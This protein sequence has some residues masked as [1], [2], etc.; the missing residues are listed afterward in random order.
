MR[1]QANPLPLA[2]GSPASALSEPTGLRRDCSSGIKD[3][4]KRQFGGDARA[5]LSAHPEVE[6]DHS[7]VVDLI[8]DEY[9]QLVDTG[10]PP[11]PDA[12]CARYPE[13]QAELQELLQAHSFMRANVDLWANGPVRSWP[14]PGTT[15]LGFSL[16]R[17][18]GRGAFSQ[19]FLARESALGG[20]LVALKVTR[21]GTSEAFTLGRLGHP[22][23][24]PVYSVREDKDTGLTAVC[25]PYLG[26]ATLAH[27][28]EHAF[29]ESRLPR[30]AAVI[31]EAVQDSAVAAEQLGPTD[32][33]SSLL[34]RGSYVEGVLLLGA[35]LAEALAFIHERGI[36]HRDLKPSNVL[37]SP[38][39][40][41]FLLDFNLAFDQ[42]LADGLLGGTWPY[43]APEQLQAT[44]SEQQTENPSLDGR[45]DLFSLGVILYELLTGKHPFG[46]IPS[47]FEIPQLRAQ[48]LERQAKGAPNAHEL[49]PDVELPLARFLNRC[50]SYSPGDRP[51]PALEMARGLRRQLAILRRA[52]RPRVVLAAGLLLLAAVIPGAVVSAPEPQAQVATS[53]SESQRWLCRGEYAYAQ[54]LYEE[55][56]HFFDRALEAD[57]RQGDALFARGRTYQQLGV[58]SK[59]SEEACADQEEKSRLDS[60][61]LRHLD[62]A[63]GDYGAVFRL[64]KLTSIKLSHR[65]VPRSHQLGFLQ[66]CIG[67]CQ[68]LQVRHGPAVA[69]YKE[70]LEAGFTT[71]EVYNNLGFEQTQ[72]NQYVAAVQYLNQA[73]RLAPQLGAARHNRAM[74]V[75]RKAQNDPT[76]DPSRGLEDMRLALSLQGPSAELYCDAAHL[77]ALA[78]RHE[79]RY[80][81]P[82]LD[83]LELAVKHGQPAEPLRGD[84]ALSTLQ[85]E[86]R[87]QNLLANSIRV[88]PSRRA[89][90]LVDPV[91]TAS[92]R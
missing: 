46:P 67:Y 49:N 8:Y 14:L 26:C 35:Q 42:R 32:P 20:R 61:K 92:E 81:E 16:L 23:I 41:P 70:A 79:A 85:K 68:G 71:A 12:F 31:L 76:Y 62:H 10:N 59:E 39:G 18:L 17:E 82:A 69:A 74:L 3:L 86:P 43:M 87:F 55:A 56:L 47:R 4:C 84:F 37:L 5:L 80:T 52:R 24:V 19:V 65:S 88:Q 27:V 60:Q 33:T 22:H 7:L 45:S 63:I 83:C 30:R 51:Q 9:C 91:S 64:M 21:L 29:A 90:R 77:Y 15:F 13:Y 66:A 2:A 38:N 34:R 75:L 73:I 58:L 1:S 40:S 44:E 57:A 48:L 6:A 54:G 50:L 53:Q 72:R 78:A 28:L 25:M 11:D 36:C 89:V